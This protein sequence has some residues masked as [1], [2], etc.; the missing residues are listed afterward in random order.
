M[1]RGFD[2]LM[3]G[4]R[5]RHIRRQRNLTL[6]EL[7]QKVGRPAPYLSMVE[8]GKREPKLTLIGELADALDVTT[9]DL[10]SLDAPSRRAF[11][12]VA[13]ARI[14]DETLYKGL[15]LPHFK[16]TAK[17]PDV[18]LEHIVS[19]YDELRRQSVAETIT[20]D[21]ARDAVSALRRDARDRGNHSK[22]IEALANAALTR[23]K[24]QGTGALSQRNVLDLAAHFGY[25]VHTVGDFPPSARA[26]ADRKNGRLY[27]PQ[28]NELRTRAARSVIL[29]TLGHVALGHDEPNDFVDFL[30]QRLEANYFA[31]AV[32]IPEQAAVTFLK[33]A[34]ARRDISIEDV[35]ERFY[36][37][38]EMAAHRFTNLATEFLDIPVHFLRTDEEGIIRRS[39]ENDG[40]PLPADVNGIVDGHRV[41]REF[42]ARTAFR[43]RFKFDIYYQYT[44]TPTGSYW[45]SAHVE[46]DRNPAHVITVG[47]DFDHA[48]WFRGRE[49]D[50]HTVSRCPDADCCALPP[51]ALREKWEHRV[52]PSPKSVSHL[53]AA[54]PVDTFP[55]V[56]M[57][58]IVALVEERAPKKD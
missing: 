47:T 7:G 32:L 40:I 55:G 49:T 53:L 38:Y 1:A 12:E 4:Q 20:P 11:L 17:T 39:Y 2:P 36:A 22:P 5:L 48:R 42:P 6:D 25:T 21:A 46:A 50:H 51:P 37:S 29:Q 14:Q 45:S 41:C 18:A 24:Y 58:E 33:E 28:R 34:K 23:V 31:G 16:P 27:I 35:K 52:W 43:S 13:S 54:L 44:D 8:T 26:I 3:F 19:L 30:Q 57:P 56:D 15:G 10:L 9:A